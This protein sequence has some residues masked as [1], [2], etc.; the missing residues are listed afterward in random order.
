MDI[1]LVIKQRLQELGLE[2]RDLAAAAQVTESYISQLLTRKKAPPAAD[3]TDLY[4]RMDGFLKLPKGQLSAMVEAQRREELKR[5][6][7]DPPAPL[8]KEVRD[9]VIRKSKTE[10]RREI[11]TIFEKQPFGELERLATQKLLDVT[12]GIVKDELK[13]ERWLR[14]VA[15]LLDRSYEEMRANILEF[16]DTDVFNVSPDHCSHFLDPLIGSWDI[17]LK[18]FEMEIWL[19]RRLA[20]TQLVRFRFAEVESDGSLEEKLGFQEFLGNAAMSGDVTQEELEFLKGLR[21]KHKRPSPL[22]Y[23]R[24][25]QNLRDPLHFPEDPV[26]AM[27]K[28]RDVGELEKQLQL[29]SR[30][31]AV[32]RWIKN[33]NRIKSEKNRGRRATTPS[34][35]R[36]RTDVN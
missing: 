35:W 25:L 5:Q 4:D 9:L 7:D 23:Y 36:G 24:E 22:Y 11:R 13:N 6:L 14:I 29:D 27:H 20:S 18:T 19:N 15:E 32:Q 8:F 10:K 3:R 33:R 12:K 31:R 26:V 28:R 30:K 1:R 34:R 17:D 16:L 2:Q 21:F